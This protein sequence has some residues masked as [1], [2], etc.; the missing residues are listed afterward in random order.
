[1]DTV[2][3]PELVDG[4]HHDLY[5]TCAETGRELVLE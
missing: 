4:D 2:V 1:M 5:A 3:Q